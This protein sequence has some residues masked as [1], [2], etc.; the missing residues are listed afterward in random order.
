VAPSSSTWD[1]SQIRK[2]YFKKA[3]TGFL[4]EV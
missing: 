3:L 4:H 1:Q 2:G